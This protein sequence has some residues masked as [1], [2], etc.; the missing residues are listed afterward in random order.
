MATDSKIQWT[1]HTVNFWTGCIKVSEG[2]KYCYMYRDKDRYGKDPKEV[3]KVKD[4]TINKVLRDAKSG[5]KIFTCSWSDFFIEEADQW[6]EWAWDII[7]SRPDLNWQI[8]TKRPERIQD[9][10][11]EDWGD[12]WDNVWLGVSVENQKNA[13]ARM[14]ILAS[15]PCKV[16]FISAEPLLDLVQLMNPVVDSFIMGDT[17]HRNIISVPPEPAL[18][19]YH[20]VIVGGESGN[21]NG[22]YRYRPSKLSWYLQIIND[23]RKQN[24]PVFLKQ[25]GTHLAKTN[26]LNDR[27]GGNI[28]EFP[29]PIRIR[30]FPNT[31]NYE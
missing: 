14:P 13:D 12:G 11:P 17:R 2:C 25:L 1:D 27:H 24:V 28:D 21:D 23:C 22:K 3:V 26:K 8:L 7:R 30:Q 9:C 29:A 15:I 18:F 5:D 4:S 6:R 19:Y 10:L 20:W 31:Q 16:R